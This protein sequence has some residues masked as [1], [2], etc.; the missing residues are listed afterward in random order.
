MV[1]DFLTANLSDAPMTDLMVDVETTGTDPAYAGMIQLAAVQ[2][3]YVTGDIGPTFNRCLA[4]APNRFWDESTREWWGRQNQDVFKDI[5]ARM[6]D[7]RA[8]MEDFFRYACIGAQPRNLS[9]PG[10]FRFWAKPLTFDWG[11]VAS[12]MRQFGL[13][14][15]FHYRVAR[16]MGT[17]IAALKGGV[18]HVSMDHITLPGDAHNAL[19]D[20]AL[21][22]KQLMAAKNNE[23]GEVLVEG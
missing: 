1:F 3:N 12:Y 14:M 15:P 5:I 22:I 13:Q 16:D 7:P 23:W 6:E 21:Q 20:C 18:E 2:F 17:H 4:L 10:G 11:F 19:Y 9:H 8:V